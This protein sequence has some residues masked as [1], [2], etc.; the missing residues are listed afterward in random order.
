MTTAATSSRPG[1]LRWA[2]ASAIAVARHPSLWVTGLRQA[3]VLARPGWWWR[4]PFLPVPDRD[5]LHFRMVT[6]YGGDGDA[7]EPADLVTY[8][9]WCRSWPAA[10]RRP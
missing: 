1:S 8:L 6:M 4:P 3:R 2:V 7:S 10:T 5:Y 9:R